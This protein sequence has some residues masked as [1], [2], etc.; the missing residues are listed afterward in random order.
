MPSIRF[1]SR[2][3][4]G[5]LLTAF[6]IAVPGLAAHAQSGSTP[7]IWEARS[8]T[9]TVYLF[10][11]IHVGARKMY[12][13]SEAVETAFADSQ[14]LA[15]EADPTDPTAVSTAA[16]GSTY[17]P[18]DNLAKHISEPLMAQVQT[19]APALGL[20]IEYAAL[21]RPAMLAMTVAMMEV[22]RAGYD[23]ALGLDL[24][25]AKR[26]KKHGKRIVELES[27][28]EQLA[29]LNGFSPA[30]QEGMLQSALASVGDGSLAVE[31]RNLVAA[32]RTG[33]AN[34][35]LVE[36]GKDTAGLPE[37]LSKEYEERLYLVRNRAMAA[38]IGA[39]LEGDASTFV[40]IGAAHLLGPQGIVE[41]LRAQHYKLRQL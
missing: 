36:L 40:A 34:G 15:L 8:A 29:L 39:M 33:D 23:P 18:P 7:M 38:K 35:L 1:V 11:T 14:V 3:F 30:R 26:A 17:S 21:M 6:I 28:T 5:R 4:A 10:G 19:A 25:F 27:I 12:P 20:P 13:L 37:N 31:L 16:A 9:N 41:L 2:R 22:G 32:W 24:Y